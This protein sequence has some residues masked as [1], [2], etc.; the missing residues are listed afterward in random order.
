MQTSLQSR[1]CLD[2]VARLVQQRSEVVSLL[3]LHHN[4]TSFVWGEPLSWSGQMSG[5]FPQS[6]HWN[7]AERN[8]HPK[9]S[10][11]LTCRLPMSRVLA[12]DASLVQPQ[13]I[14]VCMEWLRLTL[15]P[16]VW[17]IISSYCNPWAAYYVLCIRLRQV[18]RS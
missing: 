9:D 3:P 11:G 16:C 8:E 14:I 1:A 2:C 12:D 4:P 6:G 17:T 10:F 7:L 15:Q 18:C 5:A 13:S